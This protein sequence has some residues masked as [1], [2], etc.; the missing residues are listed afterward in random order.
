MQRFYIY[1]ERGLA[2]RRVSIWIY[3][4]RLQIEF[5]QNLLAEYHYK[6]DRRDKRL[7]AVFDPLWH[8]T[9]FASPQLELW[10]LDDEHWLKVRPRPYHRE[11]KFPLPNVEQLQLF[12]LAALLFLL[13]HSYHS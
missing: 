1:A 13:L 2:R 7:H 11:V 3:E 4:G 12:R 10:E 8:E 9:E 5:Q 6:Y